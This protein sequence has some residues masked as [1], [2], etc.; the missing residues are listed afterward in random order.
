MLHVAAAPSFAASH[1][2]T[3]SGSYRS[4][5]TAQAR[6][7]CRVSG[8]NPPLLILHL[9]ILHLLILHLLILHLL[10]LYLLILYLLILYLLILHR[11]H[12]T[13]LFLFAGTLNCSYAVAIN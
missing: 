1:S 3:P 8:L 11:P 4:C 12:I 7:Q 2:V 9:L 13:P 5:S 6:K 10:I